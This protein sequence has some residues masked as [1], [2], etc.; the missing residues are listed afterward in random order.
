MSRSLRAKWF[1]P[2]TA[3]APSLPSVAACVFVCTR[4]YANGLRGSWA[5]RI[6]AAV[7]TR[8]VRDAIALFDA[9][10]QYTTYEPQLE[11]AITTHLGREISG[12][13]LA[14]FTERVTHG[15]PEAH[16]LIRGGSDEERC[17]SVVRVV[18]TERGR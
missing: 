13:V 9:A 14:T 17:V 3:S 8:C 7:A 11:Q 10:R 16:Q 12:V 6:R 15:L 2:R 1:S 4:R 5:A 18:C